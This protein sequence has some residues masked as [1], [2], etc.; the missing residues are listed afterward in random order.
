VEKVNPIR[1]CA[2]CRERKPQAQ[3]QRFV[4][5]GTRPSWLPDKGRKRLP[6]RGVYLCSA[7]CVRRVEKNRKFPGLAAS[8]AE[9]GLQLG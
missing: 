3:M 8:A 9:Y 7:E 2:G 4:R 5:E 1:Q 6:G